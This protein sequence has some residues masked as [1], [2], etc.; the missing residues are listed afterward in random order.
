MI[1]AK[2]LNEGLC[3]MWTVGTCSRTTFSD[4]GKPI[5]IHSQCDREPMRR[6]NSPTPCETAAVAAQRPVRK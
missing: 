3:G 1:V 2:I 6:K 4:K 5:R